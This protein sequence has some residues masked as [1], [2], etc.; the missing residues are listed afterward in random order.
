MPPPEPRRRTDWLIVG[1]LLALSVIPVI[2]GALRISRLV[3]GV[4]GSPDDA[5]FLAS[6]AP[7][8]I[9]I[10]AVS[11]YCVLGAFQFAPGLRRRHPRWHRAAGRVLVPCALVTAVTG[12][13]MSQFY[14]RI[15]T[16]SSALYG[17]RLAVGVGIIVAILMAVSAL[18]RRDFQAH[19]AWMIRAY[20]LAQGAGTQVLTFLPWFILVGVPR[21]GVRALLMAAAW[22]INIAVAEWVIRGA[23]SRSR[24]YDEKSALLPRNVAANVG[25][26]P[27]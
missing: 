11:L 19:G 5:R 8:A 1:G 4:A 27:S 22:I 9:H 10:V 7:V 13:W 6:P 2:A 26:R 21:P 16:D 20:A 25:G 3:S 14:L 24:V 23:S 18:P 17:L 15:A 12:L